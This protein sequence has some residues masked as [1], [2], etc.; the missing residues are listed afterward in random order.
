MDRR[1]HEAVPERVHRQEGR[2]LRRVAEVVAVAAAGEGGARGRLGGDD[3]DLP[4]RRRFGQEGEGQ[5]REVGSATHAADDHVGLGAG[6]GELLAASWPTTVWCSRTWLST[7]PSA[8]LVSSRVAASSTASLI[9]MPRLPLL[10]G[11]PPGS[12]GRIRVGRRARHDLA[13]PCADHR[14]PVGLLV[15]GRPHHVDLALEPEQLAGERQRRAPLAGAGLG[16]EPCDPL[17]AVVEGLG[18]RRV[19][20]VAARRAHALVL[21]EDA[22]GGPERLLQAER[23]GG[24]GWAATSSRSRARGPGSAPSARPRPPAGSAPSGRAAPGRPGPRAGPCRGAA[25]AEAATA[26]RPRR[27]TTGGDRVLGEEVTALGHRGPLSL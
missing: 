2:H 18:H 27:C 26:G 14:A 15:V 20:L 9:A 23:R 22:A 25:A 21:V 16:G 12:R 17:L 19:R 10:V 1:G 6:L 11:P 7:L 4:A 3:P 24:A 13:P 5:P 8:Y